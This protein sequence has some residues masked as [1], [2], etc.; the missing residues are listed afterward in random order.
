MSR[1][2][3]RTKPKEEKNSSQK[4]SKKH[5]NNR[6]EKKTENEKKALTPD[7]NLANLIA[8]GYRVAR[9]E[10]KSVIQQPAVAKPNEREITRQSRSSA[11]RIF[12]R[13]VRF[14]VWE[15]LALQTSD[16]MS[17]KVSNGDVK[18]HYAKH[19]YN[20]KVTIK[21]LI[22]LF[23]LRLYLRERQHK[24]QIVQKFSSEQEENKHLWKL[25]PKRLMALQSSLWCNDW[26]E[27]STLLQTGFK[28]CIVPSQVVC[29][30]ETIYAFGARTRKRKVDHDVT[31][32]KN[33]VEV[34]ADVDADKS[35]PAPKRYI[36]RKPHPNGL[37]SYA[38][39]YKT[40]HGPYLFDFEL[41]N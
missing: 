9:S 3:R 12:L 5:H 1:K 22:Y 13:V 18:N 35:D 20:T 34:D 25:H 30:D 26:Q 14:P 11:L 40:Q 27:L 21:E 17:R 7:D 8:Q 6:I 23:G 37:L 32:E 33:E 28:R 10:L 15:F 2:K 39:A 4:H 29:F 19:H 24:A 36:P 38:A 31:D 16:N 41:D